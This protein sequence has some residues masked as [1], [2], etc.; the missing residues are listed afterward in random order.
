MKLQFAF[1]NPRG[2]KNK[3]VV[4]RSKSKKNKRIKQKLAKSVKE[5]S[6]MAKRKKK[7][8]KRRKSHK[9]KK[10]AKKSIGALRRARNSAAKAMERK[11]SKPAARK[12]ARKHYRKLYKAIKKKTGRNPLRYEARD[13][14]GQLS[15]KRQVPTKSEYQRD[16]INAHQ[17]AFKKKH[18]DKGRLTQDQI[19]AMK[20]EQDALWAEH[21]ADVAAFFKE[22]DAYK[23]QSGYSTKVSYSTGARKAA[24]KAKKASKKKASKK[25]A[26]KRK[27]GKRRAK[28]RSR[29]AYHKHARSTHHI[30]KGSTAKW[31]A[32]KERGAYKITA[33][34][35]RGKRKVRMTGTAR[36]KKGGILKGIFKFNPFGRNPM[37]AKKMR[38]SKIESYLGV[39]G[40]ELG[41]LVI[42][43]G[44]SP[45]VKKGVMKLFD[46]VGMGST[47]AP[48]L[49]TVATVGT[50][51]AINAAIEAGYGRK[52][53]QAEGAVQHLA[54]AMILI[55]LVQSAYQ[56][57]G[58]VMAKTG[59]SGV[60]Y[61][62]S[63][64]GVNYTPSMRG[65][66]IVPQLS[67]INYTPSMSGAAD[68]GAADY[69]GGGGYTEEHNRSSADFG[70]YQSSDSEAEGL[71]SQDNS[72]SSSMN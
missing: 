72:Y 35:G 65:M 32:R 50:G 14:I 66:G 61:T 39:D 11:R 68:F 30:T 31:S 51:V 5:A 70:A 23:G 63:M 8:H 37:F 3:K 7:S 22:V 46:M 69:G 27:S 40:A 57:A 4:K 13:S 19:V 71:E 25:K 10:S 60:L 48:Y 58:M 6:K 15:N 55:G 42:A 43:A 36:I 33:K 12:V 28:K 41:A 49:D 2:K 26:S 53:G 44:A 24:A 38:S 56:V 21:K 59:L 16:V 1:G 54:D 47:V 64:R 34:F 20:K 62:P 67:G 29:T 52:L 45:F 17:A 9:R 18:G